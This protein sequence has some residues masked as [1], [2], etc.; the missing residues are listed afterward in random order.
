MQ[1]LVLNKTSQFLFKASIFYL[2]RSRIISFFYLFYL[3]LVWA[4]I[5]VLIFLNLLDSV[6]NIEI[7]LLKTIPSALQIFTVYFLAILF[8]N[9]LHLSEPNSAPLDIASPDTSTG[10]HRCSHQWVP[11]GT[12]LQRCQTTAGYCSQYTA[13]LFGK[14]LCPPFSYLHIR[15]PTAGSNSSKTH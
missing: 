9:L 14:D 10:V 3:W 7:S 8:T 13:P 4:L 2:P 6:E 11:G 5:S 15:C 12:T 1:A